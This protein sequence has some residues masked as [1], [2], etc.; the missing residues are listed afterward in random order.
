VPRVEIAER[1]REWPLVT[2]AAF[3]HDDAEQMRRSLDALL[4]LDYPAVEVAVFDGSQPAVAGVVQEVALATSS[5]VRLTAAPAS[6]ASLRRP[7]QDAA[8]SWIVASGVPWRRVD[9]L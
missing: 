7:I 6:L 9:G 5:R 3:A 4:A 2:V 1:S 8:G